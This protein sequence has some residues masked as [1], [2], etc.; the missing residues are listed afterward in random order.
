M[1]EDSYQKTVKNFNYAFYSTF[2][3]ELNRMLSHEIK[4]S[5]FASR[6]LPVF[7][8]FQFTC[9]ARKIKVYFLSI[10]I[11]IDIFI[12][13]AIISSRQCRELFLRNRKRAEMEEEKNNNKQTFHMWSML[14]IF[15]C[16][17]V[18]LA[19]N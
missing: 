4:F 7:T 15:H 14:S 12:D 13:C 11:S 6:R 5:S 3:F 17:Q 19:F 2:L 10:A 16:K 8:F 9:R 1:F 18:F